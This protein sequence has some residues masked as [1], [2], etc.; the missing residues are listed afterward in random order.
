IRAQPPRLAAIVHADTSTGILQSLE[1]I[2]AACR[3]TGALL[4]VD[5]VLSI[6]GCD[7]D[8]DGW[9][10]DIAVGGLQKWL[11][12]P[13][14]P[15]LVT[16]SQRAQ[17]VMASRRTA[18]QSGYLDLTRIAATTEASSSMLQAAREALRIVLDEGLPERWQR[19]RRASQ[20]LRAG[21]DAMG[22]ER[23]VRSND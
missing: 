12:G 2:G 1:P 15:A 10:I 4:L 14:G 9:S 21:L 20:A 6:G 17:A 19:H 13:P 5:C 18:I 16:L 7:V 8:V 3:E 22:L 23:F 11:G